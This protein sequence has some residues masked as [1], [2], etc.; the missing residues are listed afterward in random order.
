MIRTNLFIAVNESR[1]TTD[2]QDFGRKYGISILSG[3]YHLSRVPFFA[4]AFFYAVHK[5]C[6]IFGDLCTPFI[7]IIFCYLW[8]SMY[9]LC[10]F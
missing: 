8:S 1:I 6:F 3:I 4:D 2:K 9:Q 10:I 7:S 5:G